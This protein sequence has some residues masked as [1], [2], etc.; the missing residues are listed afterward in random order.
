MVLRKWS[1]HTKWDDIILN[2]LVFTH[3][4]EIPLS[5]LSHFIYESNGACKLSTPDIR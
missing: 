4:N 3:L 1:Y 2:E 5:T